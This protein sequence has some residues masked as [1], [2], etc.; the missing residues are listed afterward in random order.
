MN[1]FPMLRTALRTRV[2]AFA[3]RLYYSTTP[4]LSNTAESSSSAEASSSASDPSSS[5]TTKPPPARSSVLDQVAEGLRANKQAGNT[6]N[7]SSFAPSSRTSARS[8]AQSDKFRW[9]EHFQASTSSARSQ[10][11]PSAP[12]PE[13]NWRTSQIVGYS[14]PI[15]TTTARSYPVRAGDVGRAFRLLNR[16]LR[17]NNVRRELKRQ[18][19]FESGSDKRV[20]LDSERHRKRFKVAVGKAVSLAMRMKDM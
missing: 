17:E 7:P 3:P 16:T 15:T 19:R 2:P 13:D 12:T 4:T 1:G 9:E 8:A 14:A 6:S 18:E 20:R 11:P 10:P 5:A